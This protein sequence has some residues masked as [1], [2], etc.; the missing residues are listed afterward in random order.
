MNL[1]FRTLRPVSASIMILGFLFIFQN[2][3]LLSQTYPIVFVSRNMTQGGSI[4]Y[5]PAGLLPGMGPF[6]RTAVVGGRLLVREANATIRTLVDSTMSFSGITLIDVSDPNVYWNA[7]KIVFAGIEHRDSSWRL[8]EIRA[9]GTGFKKVTYSNRNISL[10]QFGTIAYKFVK[11]DDI[12]PCYLPDGRICFSSTRYPSLSQ[13]GGKNATNL[14]VIDTTGSNLHRITTERN[15]ADEPTIDPVSGKVVYSRWWLN[16]DHPSLITSSGLTRDSAL[17]VKNDAANVWSAA[18]ITPDGEGLVMYAGTGDNRPGQNNYKPYILNDGRLLSVFVPHSPMVYTTGSSGIRW[19][20]KGMGYPN[21][22]AG[23]NPNSMQLY[24]TNPPSTGTMQPPYVTDPVELPNGKILISYASQVENQDYALY[25]VD[26]NGSGLLPYFDIA[27]KLE[28][29]AEVL[30][31]KPVPPILVDAI[32][33]FPGDLPPTADP[34][35]WF[36]D[37]GFRFDCVNMFVNGDVDEVM[38][39]APPISRFPKIKFFLNF[40]RMD[41]LGLDTPL[42]LST[43]LITHTGQIAFEHAPAN[44]SMFEQVVDSSGK[45]LVGS[46]GQV[47]HVIGM[48]FGQVGTGTKCVGCHA[49]HTDIPVPPTISE[50]AFFNTSTSANVTQ[51]SFKFISDSIQFPGKKVVDRKA[52]NDSMHVNWIA[53]GTANEFVVLKWIVPTDIRRVVLYNIRPNPLSN[54]NI[55]VNDCEI[56]CY[57]E[58]NEMAHVTST[59]PISQDGTSIDING[60]PKIDELRVFVKSYTGVVNGWNLAGLAEVETNARISYY[61]VFGITQ[62]STIADR[63]SLSQ[64]YPN[65]FNPETKIKYSIPFTSNSSHSV[66]MYVFDITG[67]QVAVLVDAMQKPGVYEV[68]F[69]AENI[70]S[71]I[72]FYKLTVDN[73]YSDFKKMVFLK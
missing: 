42:F 64:N 72:Y 35:T 48:N 30:L 66:K 16:I 28:L 10:A 52:R 22:I 26:I 59:G 11:Y 7:S 62:I 61:D 39:D 40:Q 33:A 5:P 63:F 15:G 20:N 9:D 8:Y 12:D 27:G 54:T 24:I 73:K 4:Y 13:Y 49:G 43:Q 45:V 68:D 55:Q 53:N 31:S 19:F 1:I 17:A 67:R 50:A 58:G 23:V 57:F 71:G 60:L 37:G 46:K 21:Y 51:S 65:P 32:L 2:S 41:S 38:E 34:N 44:V 69:K 36:Q 25:T 47:A 6:S 3:A 70:A 56:F 18:K 14:F 29:N